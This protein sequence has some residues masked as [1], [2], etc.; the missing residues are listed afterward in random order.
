MKFSPEKLEE[1]E[2][3]VRLE[4]VRNPHIS[5]R[6]LSK[7][8]GY[9]HKFLNFVKNKVHKETSQSITKES[10]Q[11]EVGYFANLIQ[12]TNKI[13]WEIINSETSNNSEKISAIKTLIS[14]YALL[15]DK[16]VASGLLSDKPLP[17]EKALS[18]LEA[19]TRVEEII[20]LGKRIDVLRGKIN[21]EQKAIENKN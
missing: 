7:N 10:L 17:E 21:E 18:L 15:F 9:N 2:N 5:C 4:L 19:K 3:Q 11:Q 20:S 13:L 8:L 14:A 12:E 1:I 6:G 16:K